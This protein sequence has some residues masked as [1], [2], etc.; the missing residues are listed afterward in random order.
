MASTRSSTGASSGSATWDGTSTRRGMRRPGEPQ[1]GDLADRPARRVA[2][3]RRI[4]L[5]G[6]TDTVFDDGHGRTSARSAIEGSRGTR[7]GRLRHEGRAAHRVLR[8]ACA[9]G[10]RARGVRAHHVRVQPRR[11]DRIAVLRP[12]DPRARAREHDVGVRPGG[13]AR[14]RR[15]RVRAQGRS[16]TT[17]LTVHGRAAHAGVEPEKGRNAIAAAPT[18]DRASAGAQ[19][20]LARRDGERR[21]DRGRHAYATSS[22]SGACSQV[23]LRSPDARDPRGGASARSSASV[24]SRRGRTSRSR[25]SARRWHR[26]MEKTPRRSPRSWIARSALRRGARVRAPRRGDR[27]GVRR[28]HDRA[29]RAPR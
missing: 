18:L 11:G 20:T 12:G 2:A 7:P 13:R 28:E 22:P 23:D 16:P 10:R 3:D 15:H 17:T 24:P 5:V 29:P 27:R 14:Q 26:P 21:H 8:D 1:L 9:A 4:L 25:W 19:R 6:H